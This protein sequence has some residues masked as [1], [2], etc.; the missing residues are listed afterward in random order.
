MKRGRLFVIAPSAHS[1]GGVQ[2]WLGYLIPGLRKLGWEVVLGLTRGKTHDP[3][4]YLK[5]YPEDHV[6]TIESKTGS[7]E[8]RVR[9]VEKTIQSVSADIVVSV[10]IADVYLA[11]NRLKKANKTDARIIA[12]C[13]GVQ[14]SFLDDYR[15]FADTIDGVIS[16]NRL[17][18]AL[19]TRVSGIE[20]GRSFY[21]PYGVQ[22]ASQAKP[23][24]EG[25]A[26]IPQ[27]TVAF[28]GRFQESQ[29]RISDMLAIL[30]GFI[31]RHPATSV[32]IAGDGPERNEVE[33]WVNKQASQKISYLG[34]LAP[35]D[36]LSR[37]YDKADVL[38]VTS[39][40]E[41]GP[42]VAWEAMSQGIA[43]VTSRY[44]GS[45]Q[46]GSLVDGENCLMFDVGDRDQGIGCL[47]K[48][49]QPDARIAI[50]AAGRKMVESRYSVN[51]SL[52]SWDECFLPFA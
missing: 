43:L 48:A 47:E 30:E 11:A 12:T 8:G 21:A 44:V 23:E 19:V 7:K 9:A 4:E 35:S 22:W 29:K 51:I 18:Q 38:L 3:D 42:I 17:T 10:N 26:G 33:N 52:K 46:E 13:H 36:L 1:L 27:L 5:T 40:W 25:T 31:H 6:V 39:S 41:T 45:S 20:A 28:V 14:N 37:V 2:V 24:K 49:L 50:G 15:M 34:N 16:T 32:L